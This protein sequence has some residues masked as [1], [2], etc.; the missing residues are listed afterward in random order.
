MRKRKHE[1]Q[2]VGQRI[3]HTHAPLPLAPLH[4]ACLPPLQQGYQLSRY[5]H[6]ILLLPPGNPCAA[7]G[8]STQACTTTTGRCSSWLLLSDAGSPPLS[9]TLHEIGHTFG[10]SHS[11]VYGATW[12]Q[13]DTSSLMGASAPM[14]CFAAPSLY[15]LGW[16]FQMQDVPLDSLQI[17]KCREMIGAMPVTA[18]WWVPVPAG[19]LQV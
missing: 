5:S 17:G 4:P 6:R 3:A 15:Q 1:S 10:L 11:A 19:L 2:L 14:R 16:T 18:D 9:N 7:A 12:E 8:L 13:G